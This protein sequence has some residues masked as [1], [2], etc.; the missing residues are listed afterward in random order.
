MRWGNAE[1]KY[2]SGSYLFI[3][4]NHLR[5]NTGPVKGSIKA[6]QL[7]KFINMVSFFL[8]TSKRNCCRGPLELSGNQ[9]GGQTGV[10]TGRADRL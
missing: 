7:R 10:E 6:F 8:K 9:T 2:R 1:P 4:T 3:C 5:H